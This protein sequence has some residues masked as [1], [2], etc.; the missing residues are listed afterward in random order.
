[1]LS[2]LHSSSSSLI[3]LLPRAVFAYCPLSSK[4]EVVQKQAGDDTDDKTATKHRSQERG[5][6]ARSFG[7]GYLLRN[8]DTSNG[9]L[10]STISKFIAKND[11][12]IVFPNRF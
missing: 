5:E 4:N 10:V 3:R 8:V 9:Y 7:L 12:L 6:S 2:R 11:A 1:M